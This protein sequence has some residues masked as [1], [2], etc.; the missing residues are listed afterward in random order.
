MTENVR[1]L[2][3]SCL[4]GALNGMQLDQVCAV[5]E[6]MA[7]PAEDRQT[8][9]QNLEQFKKNIQ[10]RIDRLESRISGLPDENMKHVG[11]ESIKKL[12]SDL[13]TVNTEVRSA[14]LLLS[15]I[16]LENELAEIERTK[17]DPME[18]DAAVAEPGLT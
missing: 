7:K 11:L 15:L 12:R 14:F 3:K 10:T 13:N 5:T 16:T 2:C 9:D 6:L 1:N 18:I 8:D 4:S 17:E